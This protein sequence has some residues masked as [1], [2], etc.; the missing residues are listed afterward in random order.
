[1]GKLALRRLGQSSQGLLRVDFHKSL[2]ILQLNAPVSGSKTGKRGM[3][4]F[5]VNEEPR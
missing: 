5:G 3:K 4:A 2:R 1:M